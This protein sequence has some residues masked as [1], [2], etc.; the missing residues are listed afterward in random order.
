MDLIEPSSQALQLLFTGD[1]DLWRIIFLSFWISFVALVLAA[2]FAIAFGFILATKKFRGRR[3]LV[4]FSQA[5]MS[6][7]T[8]VIGLILYVLLSRHGPLGY[9]GLL[10]TPTAMVIGQSII[11]FPV[12]VAYTLSAVQGADPRAWETAI[13]LGA[14]PFSASIR[15]LL[16]VRFAVMAGIFTGFGRVISEVGCSLMVGGNVQGMTRNIPTAIALQTSMGAFAQGIALGLVLVTLALVVN[17]SLAILQG[18]GG[19][20]EA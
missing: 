19:L 9:F 8:V 7:P 4:I 16:E 15:T 3:A 11:C 1:P 18:K 17:F 6:F 5:M 20:R 2:P 14:S 12:L 10:F 13:A